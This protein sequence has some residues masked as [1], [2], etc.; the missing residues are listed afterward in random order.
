MNVSGLERCTTEI[1]S[2]LSSAK[3]GLPSLTRSGLPSFNSLRTRGVTNSSA[4]EVSAEE[5]FT[6]TA[7][8]SALMILAISRM[9][10]GDVL[11]M[12]LAM[13]SMSSGTLASAVNISVSRA[14]SR[15][16]TSSRRRAG[17]I[18][19]SILTVE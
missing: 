9:T 15:L 17:D 5:T 12:L 2:A 16:F 14:K 11:W 10:P 4:S 6:T 8:D 18:V 19:K 13:R 7:V 1:S 3:S